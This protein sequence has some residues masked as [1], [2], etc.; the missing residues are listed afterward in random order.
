[1]RQSLDEE[2]SDD[3]YA[4]IPVVET[5]RNCRDVEGG[6]RGVREDGTEVFVQPAEG[7]SIPGVPPQ[8]RLVLAN[9]GIPTGI[10]KLERER[11]AS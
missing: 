11:A 2:L 10:I 8:N 6:W 5:W 9:G 1:M 7:C 4:G 3:I